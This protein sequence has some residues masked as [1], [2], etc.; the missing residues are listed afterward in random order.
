MRRAA[1]DSPRKTDTYS[2]SSRRRTT[3]SKTR[4]RGTKFRLRYVEIKLARTQE[5]LEQMER[6]VGTEK[7]EAKVG[8]LKAADGGSALETGADQSCP[9]SLD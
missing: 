7:D 6:R 4:K 1:A 9:S 8:S 5:Q 2:V 3:S